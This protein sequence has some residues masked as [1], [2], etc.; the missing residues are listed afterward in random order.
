MNRKYVAVKKIVVPA[1]TV[2]LVTSSMG[3]RPALANDNALVYEVLAE[4]SR[5]EMEI[6]TEKNEPVVYAARKI[7]NINDF[8]DASVIRNHWGKNEIQKLLDKGGIAGYAD[9]SFRPNERITTAELLSILINTTGNSIKSGKGSWA[10]R[11]METAYDLGII[12]NSDIPESEGNIAI[13]R[14]KMALILVN[15]AKVLKGE[16]TDNIKLVDSRL[17][18]D[19][20]EAGEVYRESIIKAYSIGLLAG[21]GKGYSPKSNTTRAETCAIVN[22]L[23]KYSNRVDNSSKEIPAEKPIEK[24]VEKPVE[25]PAEKP[26]KQGKN[27]PGVYVALPDKSNV[28]P[29]GM[30]L[31]AE[32]QL[33]KDGKPIS[34][35]KETGVLGYGGSQT[36]G[37]YLGVKYGNGAQIETGDG[38]PAYAAGYDELATGNYVEFKGYTYWTDEWARIEGVIGN[39]LDKKY[40]NAKDGTFA[41]IYGNLCSEKEACFEVYEGTWTSIIQGTR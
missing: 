8:T 19:L 14:E 29:D 28:L 37:I 32:G 36:G 27:Q 15:S 39:K 23:M 40:P 16:D 20:G 21:T 13:S 12:T 6:T 10:N 2:L 25:K 4:N 30:T 7:T 3:L 1:L 11:V 31:P 33:D 22:R 38:A 9:G 18:S 34:R 24:P 26:V 5:I 41:D 17:I 35:D